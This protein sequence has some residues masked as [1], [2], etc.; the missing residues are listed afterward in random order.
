MT[1]EEH[2][3]TQ[4]DTRSLTEIRRETEQTRA[5][6]STT[7]D[8]LRGTVSDRAADIKSRLQPEAL[9]AEVSSYI[10]SRGERLLQDM[11]EA[12]RRNPMQAVAVGA[13]VAYPAIKI[14]RAIPLPILMIG[15][16]LFLAGSKTGQELTQ[17]ASDM[18]SDA[19]EEASRRVDDIRTKAAD[20]S[21]Q[22]M[23][24]MSDMRDRAGETI[25]R[26]GEA[27]SGMARQASDQTNAIA[28]DA[29][30]IA[31]HSADTIQAA[32][33]QVT[34][35]MRGAQTRVSESG[36]ELFAAAREHLSEAGD[37]LSEVGQKAADTVRGSIQRNPMLIAGLGLLVGGLIASVLP[38]SETESNLVG[39]ASNKV[40]RKAREAAAA[41]FESAK[42]ATGEIFANVAQQASAE[43]LTPDAM[44]E[45]AQD[46][47]ERVQRVAER[48]VT[49][50]FD[51]DA[52]DEEH[53]HDKSNQN[54]GIGGGQQNG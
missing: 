28:T 2:D 49:T 24:A 43:G 44:A 10:K 18:A 51:P 22:T 53:D 41:G 1:P 20:I 16:G 26:A 17:K 9:K 46:I 50:A 37:N 54:E 48:A 32:A 6:L 23:Q 21:D 4:S 39:E 3:M 8:E 13:S 5:A 14:A 29:S 7:V 40:K 30:Q 15:A 25:D 42:S 36:R 52:Q 19:A 34:G 12:A 27:L 31:G 45:G 47:R 38:K 33:S 35:A 11:T